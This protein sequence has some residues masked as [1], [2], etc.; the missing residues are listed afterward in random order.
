MQALHQ[1]AQQPAPER[2]GSGVPALAGAAVV[3][4]IASLGLILP[5]VLGSLT[6]LTPFAA[7][8]LALM[9][10]ISI[11]L[12]LKSREKPLV[13]ADIILF[14]L[15]AFVAYGRWVIVP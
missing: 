12:H 9:M 2:Q 5:A 15:C 7:T 1:A 13:F 6:W 10:G 4:F 3:M 8:V 11:L 14:V